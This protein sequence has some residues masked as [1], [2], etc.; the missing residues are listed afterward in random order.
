MISCLYYTLQGN[1]WQIVCADFFHKKR[2]RY[3]QTN[4]GVTQMHCIR[5]RT[6][7]LCGMGAGLAAGMVAGSVLSCGKRSMKTQLGRKIQKLGVAVD[8]ALDSMKTDLR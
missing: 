5:C 8:H 4:E 3:R 2:A 6:G 7:F 1:F